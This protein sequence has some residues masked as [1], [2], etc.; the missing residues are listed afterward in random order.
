MDTPLTPARLP[1]AL[2]TK[3]ASVSFVFELVWSEFSNQITHRN[4]IVFWGG[5]VNSINRAYLIAQG[6]GMESSPKVMIIFA[7]KID[8][9]E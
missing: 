2:V 6:L 5:A 8:A 9:L 1:H 3:A 7:L 4:L